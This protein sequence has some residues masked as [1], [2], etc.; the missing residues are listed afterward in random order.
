MSNKDQ[1]QRRDPWV[2]DD[3]KLFLFAP[4]LQEGAR[5]RRLR[6]TQKQG[7]NNPVFEID[8]GIKSEG[9]NGKEG[10]PIKLEIPMEPI[11]F[12]SIMKLIER[13][14]AFKGQCGFEFEHWGHPFIWN[15]DQGKSIRSPERMLLARQ[16]IFKKDNGM[17]VMGFASKGKPDAEFEFSPNEFHPIM[18]NGQPAAL[19]VSSSLAAAGW[20]SAMHEVFFNHFVK[21]W[22]E[23]AWEKK[24]RLEN[25]QRANGGGSGGY[26][27]GGQGGYQQPQQQQQSQPS[28]GNVGGDIDS[29]DDDLPF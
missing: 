4:P 6:L 10:Y 12:S 23:P 27:G 3:K 24:R 20:A 1:K 26:G 11:T 17:V 16:S 9:R 8:Y 18:Q 7:E 5:Q 28:G 21:S 15:K 22:E 29:F 25:M 13:V 2:L 19:D 14:A